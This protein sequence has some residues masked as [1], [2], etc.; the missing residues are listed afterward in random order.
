[1][2]VAVPGGHRFRALAASSQGTCGLTLSGAALCWGASFMVNHWEPTPIGQAAPF[3]S[4]HGSSGSY[5][6]L[7]ADGEAWCWG[8]GPDGRIGS[9]GHAETGFFGTSSPL[10]VAGGLRFRQISPGGSFT[11]GVTTTSQGYCWGRAEFAPSTGAGALCMGAFEGAP[12]TYC[13]P[14][15]VPVE[16]GHSWRAIVAGDIQALGITTDGQLY[17]WSF[18][19]TPETRGPVPIATQ[20]EF[21][22]E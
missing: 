3:V 22:T 1:V 2:P 7:T 8:A 12:S 5:C 14:T 10:R 16:G 20:L 11:C 4:I 21:P 18:N 13:H 17:A 19:G 6:A 9:G 15:P